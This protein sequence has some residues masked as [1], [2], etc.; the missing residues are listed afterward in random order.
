MLYQSVCSY[1][2]ITC[3]YDNCQHRAVYLY[4]V[5]VA[6]SASL[7]KLMLLTSVLTDRHQTLYNTTSKKLSVPEGCFIVFGGASI[8][9]A[10]HKTTALKA[11]NCRCSINHFYTMT[12]PTP[13][14][15]KNKG[16]RPKKLENELRLYPVKVYFDETNYRKLISR[17]QRTGQSLSTIVYELAV[18][19]YVKEP[20]PHDVISLLRSLA[21]MANNLNQIAREAHVSNFHHVEKRAREVASKIDDLLIQISEK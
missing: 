16:G 21:G 18:N 17:S 2:H 6:R 7:L 20:I 10:S 19:G 5:V 11:E 3:Y 12:P 14:T 13:N 9:F 1:R 15:R 4:E 8:G